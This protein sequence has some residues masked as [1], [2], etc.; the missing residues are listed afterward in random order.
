MP[1]LWFNPNPVAL[2]SLLEVRLVEVV[3]YFL[4]VQRRMKE[5][6]KLKIEMEMFLVRIKLNPRK[7]GRKCFKLYWG[8]FNYLTQ[9]LL[10]VPST[11]SL[12]DSVHG[13]TRSLFKAFS[14]FSLLHSFYLL[15]V[16][17]RDAN[18]GMS[19]CWK[20][21]SIQLFGL[22]WNTST[23]RWIAM[24]CSTGI[25]SFLRQCIL[26]SRSVGASPHTCAGLAWLSLTELDKGPSVNILPP[27]GLPKTH[28]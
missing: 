24:K 8:G 18:T 15:Y 20:V 22:N 14:L 9:T 21:R 28:R 17:S 10:F 4:S 5:T 19:V 6:E 23:V 7:L 26:Y 13:I 1:G 11:A 16:G 2:S 3:H 27:C 12:S 25:Q